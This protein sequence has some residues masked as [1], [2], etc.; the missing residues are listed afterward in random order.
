MIGNFVRYGVA[1]TTLASVASIVCMYHDAVVK[2]QHWAEQYQALL[3]SDT[4]KDTRARVATRDV[5]NCDAAERAAYDFGP[6]VAAGLDTLRALSVCGVQGNVCRD[7]V[8]AL[9]DGGFKLC[10]LAAMLLL[11]VAWLVIHK[12]RTDT[13]IRSSLPLD[14]PNYPAKVP[15][16]CLK[17]D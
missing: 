1:V 10:L 17:T 16:Y 6:Y 8:A 3:E 9:V 4:C 14:T 5:N 12:W 2:H 7:V 13:L 15:V 11:A